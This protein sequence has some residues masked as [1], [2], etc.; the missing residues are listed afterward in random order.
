MEQCYWEVIREPQLLA[1]IKILS[2]RKELYWIAVGE[3]F[4][5]RREWQTSRSRRVF[6]LQNIDE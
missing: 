2:T 3:P 1:L 6:I 5:L 4:Y